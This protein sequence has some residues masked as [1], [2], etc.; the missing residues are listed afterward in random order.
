MP[1]INISSE[2]FTVVTPVGNV[3]TVTEWGIK[4]DSAGVSTT[5]CWVSVEISV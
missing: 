5:I 2:F 3:P 1:T 4:P